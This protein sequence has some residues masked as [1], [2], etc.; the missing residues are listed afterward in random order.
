[1]DHSQSLHHTIGK[2]TAS[3]CFVLTDEF[4]EASSTDIECLRCPFL[5]QALVQMNVIRSTIKNEEGLPYIIETDQ[6]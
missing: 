1:M 6:R 3:L 5:I 2:Q 4:W